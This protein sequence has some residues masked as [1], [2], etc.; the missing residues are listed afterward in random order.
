MIND[1]TTL[2]KIQ[3]YEALVNE[4]LRNKLK[5]CLKTRETYSTEIQEYLTLQ[6]TIENLKELDVNPLKT[7]VDLGCGFF[8]QAEVPDVS[9]VL[10]SI[11]YG[12]FLELTHHEACSFITK[13]IKQI[14][15]RV[16]ALEEEAT[17]I[18]ADIKMMLNTLAQLQGIVSDV[19]NM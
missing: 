12:F 15:E 1:Q 14:N 19:S 17:H 8:V 2:S 7:K 3:Q 16:K 18:N 4:V 5:I 13:K 6:K 10:V 9:T 11:G